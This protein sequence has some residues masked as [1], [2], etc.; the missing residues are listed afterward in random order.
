[1]QVVSPNDTRKSLRRK[2]SSVV[3]A[4]ELD[5]LPAMNFG[6]GK[7]GISERLIK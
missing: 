4:E 5:C 6:G 7:V 1:M 2:D 3:L